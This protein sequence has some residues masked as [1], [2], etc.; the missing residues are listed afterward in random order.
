MSNS[1]KKIGINTIFLTIRKIITLLIAFYSTRLLLSRLGEA[2]FGLYGLIGSIVILFSAI[3]GFFSTS[4]QRFI[5]AAKGQENTSEINEIFSY[6]LKIH[7]WIALI[8]IIVVEVGGIL[9]LPTLNLPPDSTNAAF[10]VLQFTVLATVVTILTIP[11]DAII[12][13]HEN[14]MA[15]SIIAV[16]ESLLKLLIVAV[17]CYIDNKRIVVYSALYFGVTIFV[18]LINNIYC[19]RKFG[20]E[21]RYHNKRNPKLLHQMMTFAGWQFFG[22]LGYSL[23]NSGLNIIINYFGGVIVN[24]A[25]TIAYQ[26]MGTVS[27]FV[28]DMNLSFQTQTIIS[29]TNG[30]MEKFRNL[31][32][33]NT[34]AAFIM[35]ICIAV[36]LFFCTPGF[37][38][39]WL[40]NIPP[41]TVSFTRW[42]LIYMIIRSLHGPIDLMFKASARLKTYQ[43][44]ELIV[45]T[46][47]LPISWIVLKFG[48]PF[49][50]VFA[51]MASLE[52]INLMA[53]INLASRQLEFPIIKYLKLIVSR[54]III[55]AILCLVYLLA[56]SIITKEHNLW[57]LSII[58]LSLIII[59]GLLSFFILLNSSERT[60]LIHKLM[61]C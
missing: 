28:S 27:Q 54:I 55:L 45:M 44:T 38:S 11:Y 40:G 61:P 13:A 46:M 19:H 3:R 26:L 31:I 8:F 47:N 53:I 18:R 60:A 12:I 14:F 21:V 41:Y 52:L 58:A 15:Y 20:E 24:A 57:L 17:L 7:V 1:T 25:R 30:D 22:N 9:L 37:L 43:L 32:F 39:I 16:I 59:T 2:D 4:I 48:C 29:Y 34:K 6:G 49:C 42:I 23:T 5:N 50:S 56:G 33:L 36:P 51:V 35:G 10:W